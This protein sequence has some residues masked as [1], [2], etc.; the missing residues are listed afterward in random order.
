MTL[1][2]KVK[3]GEVDILLTNLVSIVQ[4]I[5]VFVIISH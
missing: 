4:A 2:E 3:N 1:G 5:I